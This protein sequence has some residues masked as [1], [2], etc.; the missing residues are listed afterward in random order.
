MKQNIKYNVV[1][2]HFRNKTTFNKFVKKQM[3]MKHKRRG[4]RESSCGR[5][6][7][8]RSV[9][10]STSPKDIEKTPRTKNTSVFVN[11]KEV[12]I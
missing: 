4:R 7:I 11:D 9:S 2:F 10:R 8:S 3:R 1:S 6:R 5:G 12:L